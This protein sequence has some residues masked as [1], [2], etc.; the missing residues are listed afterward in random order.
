MSAPYHSGHSRLVD[1]VRCSTK[2]LFPEE[3]PRPA[4]AAKRDW[5]RRLILASAASRIQKWYRDLYVD[6]WNTNGIEIVRIRRS[7][8]LVRLVEPSRCIYWFKGSDLAL[9]FVSIVSALHPITRREFLPAELSRI[10]KSLKRRLALLFSLTLRYRDRVKEA[11]S[12]YFSLQSGLCTFAGEK[13]DAALLDAELDNTECCKSFELMDEYDDCIRNVA[14]HS[15]GRAC[16]DLLR[17]HEDQACRREG[18]CDPN[19]WGMILDC[20]KTSQRRYATAGSH[21]SHL[22]AFVYWMREGSGQS[23]R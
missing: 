16:T 19:V 9:A 21:T 8:S 7:K 15:Q 22:P 20:I 6:V 10:A 23:M 1:L 4:K 14:K 5:A 13:L 12:N 3:G 18:L 17:L 11:Q 2:R